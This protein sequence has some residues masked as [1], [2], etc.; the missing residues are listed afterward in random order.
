MPI[1]LNSLK[2]LKTNPMGRKIKKNSSK[3]YLL[4]FKT[5]SNKKIPRTKITKP[6]I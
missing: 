4:E 6:H 2:N 1:L 5:I 3:I